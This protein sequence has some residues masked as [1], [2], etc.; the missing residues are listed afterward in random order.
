MRDA[1]EAAAP[2]AFDLSTLHQQPGAVFH[3]TEEQEQEVQA[4]EEAAAVSGSSSVRKSSSCSTSSRSNGANSSFGTEDEVGSGDEGAAYDDGVSSSV[5]EGEFV[6]EWAKAGWLVE[7][8][9]GAPTERENYV[10]Q[11]KGKVFRVLLVR[12]EHS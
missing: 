7:N 3:W 2:E 6:S 9:I 8:P 1:I 11:Q 10:M 4:A 5:D 12:N